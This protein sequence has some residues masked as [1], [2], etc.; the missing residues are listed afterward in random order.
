MATVQLIGILLVFLILVGLMMTRKVP[1]ILALPIMAIAISLIAGITIISKD[2]EQFTIVKDVLE[3]GSM[4]M[5]TAISGLIFGSL[6]GKVLSKVGVTETIIKKAAEMAGDKALPIALSFLAVCS[7]IFAASNGLGMV[8]LV[9]TI[10]IP[11]MI[12][13]GLSPMVSG[14]ILLLSNGIGVTFSVSTLAVYIDVLG[15]KLSEVT[16]YSWMV[17]LPLVIVSVMMV[18]YYV[19]FSGKRRKAW[20]MPTKK[21]RNGQ[22]RSIALISPIIPVVLVFAFQVPLVAAII[23]GIIGTLI[24]STPK[25][26]IHVVSSAFVEGIQEVAGAAGLMIGIGM[27]L[28]AVMSAEVSAILQPAISMMI[29]KNQLMFILIFGLLS[30]LAIYRGPL[31]VWGLGSGII[32]LLVAGGMNPIAAMVALRL[33]SNVQAVCDPTNSHNVWVSDFIKTDVNEVMKKTIGW[34]AVST[35]IGLIVA[36]FFLY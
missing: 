4:R 35:F 11:I 21:G 33:D 32:S 14:I 26:P 1:T 3:S 13:A 20:A 15:L 16:S 31:N 8:I 25:N 6:F 9:G 12:S 5:S 34:V 10:I 22:V 2:V 19:N 29:P 36:S 27:L 7:V 28:N 17:G 23:V 30:P 18:I 24:L